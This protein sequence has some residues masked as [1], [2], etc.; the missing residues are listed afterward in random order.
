MCLNPIA[1]DVL[2]T[3]SSLIIAGMF[4]AE[5]QGLAAGVFNTVS[6]FGRTIGLALVALIA[7]SVTE[8]DSTSDN[9]SPGALMVGYRASFWFLFAMNI[10]SLVVSLIGLRK[11]GNVG[12]KG[13]PDV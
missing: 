9:D 5:T 12:R 3:V 2:F 11:I 6:Q 13:P 10:T 7:N 1:A 8:K 4:P